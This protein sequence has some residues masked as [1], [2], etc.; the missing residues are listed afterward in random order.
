MVSVSSADLEHKYQD[1]IAAMKGLRRDISSALDGAS[2]QV[3]PNE[4]FGASSRV[5]NGK[6]VISIRQGS[7]DNLRY[8]FNLAL[9]H[10]DVLA[11][12]GDS[13]DEKI[14]EINL[15]HCNWS[16]RLSLVTGKLLHDGIPHDVAPATRSRREAAACLTGRALDFLFFHE[17]GHLA[18]RHPLYRKAC[19]ESG[20]GKCVKDEPL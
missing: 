6:G 14:R 9:S 7:V 1:H 8:F 12:I 18:F 17:S 19:S 15:E 10:P 3:D 5:Q 4:A 2:F 13:K 20:G 11:G 16:D